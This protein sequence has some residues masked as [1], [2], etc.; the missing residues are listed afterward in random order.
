ML[1]EQTKAY[2]AYKEN[3]LE[4]L[5]V[6]KENRLEDVFLF[7]EIGERLRNDLT[8]SK[9]L[10]DLLALY[11]KLARLYDNNDWRETYENTPLLQLKQ[12]LN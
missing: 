4:I 2:D 9:G 6:H 12:E 10:Y 8:D 5:V 7:D 1:L 3:G 11:R